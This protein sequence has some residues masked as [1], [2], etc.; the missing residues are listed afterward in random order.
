MTPIV[1]SRCSLRFTAAV[2]KPDSRTQ[3]RLRD[4]R[5]VLQ[6]SSSLMSTSSNA[7]SMTPVSGALQHHAIFLRRTAALIASL[8]ISVEFVARRRQLSE[9][10]RTLRRT[11]ETMA[12][13]P[14]SHARNRIRRRRGG[15]IPREDLYRSR[16]SCTPVATTDTWP[17]SLAPQPLLPTVTSTEPCDCLQ[18]A[19][20]PGTGAEAMLADGLLERFPVD[21][22]YG[23]HNIPGLPTGE[24]HVRS[25]SIMA[26]E[27]NFEIH[28]SGRG[29]HAS[30][31]HLV[32]DPMV[33][34]AEVVLALQTIVSRDIDPLDSVVVSCTELVTD[35]ARNAIPGEATIRGDV[36]TFTDEDSALVESRMREIAEGVGIA[37][38]ATCSVDYTRVFR[39]TI[40]DEDCVDHVI[41]AA[42]SA[43]GEDRVNG[44]GAAITASEDF[45]AYARAVPACFAFLGAGAIE[46]GGTAPP[47]SRNF[48]FN[49]SI[50]GMGIDFYV[51]LVHSLLTGGHAK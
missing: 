17:W 31:P 19:E 32:I 4:S 10:E 20:E 26:A 12:P 5:I 38:R 3:R 15:R 27:D 14:A 1:V 47:H 23:L 35:G 25:G 40:N 11:R 7:R 21:A 45:A 51:E 34:G 42:T 41:S 39:P 13:R 33:A 37:H 48:D 50:L 43:L 29:G 6:G 28:I 49:D 22:V 36:R 24:L 30:T 18:P 16:A 46:P 2:D 44:A 9:H 8:F